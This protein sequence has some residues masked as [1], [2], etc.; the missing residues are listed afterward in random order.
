MGSGLWIPHIWES[1]EDTQTILSQKAGTYPKETQE[2][3]SRDS[4]WTAKQGP[5]NWNCLGD[6]KSAT[7]SESSRGE[8][9]QGERFLRAG[10]FYSPRVE[11][12]QRRQ[13]TR[14]HGDPDLPHVMGGHLPQSYWIYYQIFAIISNILSVKIILY[15]SSTLL[16]KE[17]AN[18]RQGLKQTNELLIFCHLLIEPTLSLGAE[19]IN[20]TK[21]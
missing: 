21:T 12:D 14:K 6:Q 19:D 20:M 16:G 11:A 5:R 2:L 10:L 9:Q 18:I 3:N 1:K 13:R 17:T 8:R 7:D 4:H 15:I